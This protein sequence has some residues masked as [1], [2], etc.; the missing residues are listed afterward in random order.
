M[1]YEPKLPPFFLDFVKEEHWDNHIGCCEKKIGKGV[2]VCV[3]YRYVVCQLV[4]G[5]LFSI[6][7]LAVP[8]A[9]M[10]VCI[11]LCLVTI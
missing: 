5:F 2:C 10:C 4:N 8:F 6:L 3:Y 9:Q 11:V 1:N 7:I